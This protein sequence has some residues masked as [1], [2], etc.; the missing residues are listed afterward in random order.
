MKLTPLAHLIWSASSR[1]CMKQ[2]SDNRINILPPL[3]ARRLNAR[4][5]SRQKNKDA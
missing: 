5:R 3:L 4:Q 2:L 1:R